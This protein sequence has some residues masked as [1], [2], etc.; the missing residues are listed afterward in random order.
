MHAKTTRRQGTWRKLRTTSACMSGPLVDRE[1]VFIENYG[2][3]LRGELARVIYYRPKNGRRHDRLRRLADAGFGERV[4]VSAPFD[5]LLYEQRRLVE[6]L[7]AQR[8]QPL[9]RCMRL[10]GVRRG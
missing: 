7:D 6:D 3:F 4:L 10:E 2:S 8:S 1:V 9:D 5:G